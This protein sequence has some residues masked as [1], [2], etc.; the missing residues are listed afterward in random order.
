M[1]LL[2]TLLSLQSET[3]KKREKNIITNKIW[4]SIY[5]NGYYFLQVP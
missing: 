2:K 3:N 5:I 4:N 1:F